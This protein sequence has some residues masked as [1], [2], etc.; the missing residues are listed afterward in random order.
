MGIGHIM[1]PICVDYYIKH[2]FP[3]LKTFFNVSDYF[4]KLLVLHVT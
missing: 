1:D 3:I 2:I 4:L